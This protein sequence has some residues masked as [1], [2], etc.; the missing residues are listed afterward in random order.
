MKRFGRNVLFVCLCAFG[1]ALAHQTWSAAQERRPEPVKII[2]MYGDAAGE[3]HLQPTEIPLSARI[4]ATGEVQFARFAADLN[5]DWHAGT[6]HRY[7]VPLSGAGFEIEVTDG[8]K[9]Q[10]RPGTVLLADDMGSKGHRTRA[11]GGETLVMYVPVDVDRIL[12]LR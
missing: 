11:L 1:L 12:S 6:L 3:T 4:P 2:R 5:A 9:A 10:F 7:V 8:S